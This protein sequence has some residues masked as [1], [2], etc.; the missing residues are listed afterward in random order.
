MSLL[1]GMVYGYTTGI[2]A[3]IKEPAVNF[4]FNTQTIVAVDEHYQNNWTCNATSVTF[5]LV[6]LQ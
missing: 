4:M 3:G 1:T 2:V 6:C 5:V